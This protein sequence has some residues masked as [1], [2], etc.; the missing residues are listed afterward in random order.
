MAL[1]Q[2]Q[3]NLVIEAMNEDIQR[4][5]V[6]ER[7]VIHELC[8]WLFKS[9]A[10]QK[11]ELLRIVSASRLRKEDVVAG[12]DTEAAAS[13]TALQTKIVDLTAVEAELA[14]L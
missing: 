3:K 4:R 12:F 1:T 13:K 2:A 5:R 8:E 6:D 7:V 10:A 14:G 11:A 9:K